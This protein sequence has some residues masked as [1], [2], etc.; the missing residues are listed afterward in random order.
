MEAKKSE[1]KYMEMGLRFKAVREHLDMTLDD[2]SKETGI[3][4]GYISDF[5]R[6][7]KLPTGKYMRH[8]HDKHG[9]NLNFLFTSEGRMLRPISG[10]ADMDFGKHQED[11]EELLK[12]MA[13]IPHAL[14]AML[15][16]FAEYK[17]GNAHI[18]EKYF[19]G[20]IK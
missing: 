13:R 19:P 5:E 17:M 10:E 8:L 15:G 3:S 1:R 18:I 6:G 14:Y 4:R 16:F 7:Y 20:E 11:I 9:I 2:M 12:V